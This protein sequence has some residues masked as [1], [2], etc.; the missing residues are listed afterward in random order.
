MSNAPFTID[1]LRTGI[2]LAYKNMEYI[3]DQALPRLPTTMRNYKYTLYNK[4]DR[5]T[6]PDTTIGRKGKVNEVEFG[7]TELTSMVIDRGLSDPIPQADIDAAANTDVD[8]LSDAAESVTDLIMLDREVRVA[9]I[10]MSASNYAT[11][12]A[13]SGT[14]QWDDPASD[15]IVQL[16]DAINTPFM[17]C[18]TLVLGRN[19]ANALRKNPAV[20]KAFNGTLGDSGL[21]PLSFLEQLLDIRILVGRA[22]KNT[23]NP[24]QTLTLADVWGTNAALYYLSP[25][26]KVNKGVTWGWTAEFKTREASTRQ[27]AKGEFGLDGG[28]SVLVGERLDEKVVCTD[29]G[30]IL[31]T[32]I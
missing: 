11:S 12:T 6:I 22:R 25:T 23:A 18:N 28:I 26:A 2:V 21:V 7:A 10:V 20:I 30:H 14:D 17:V 15:P 9:G 4:A 32:V 3:A 27:L 8:P 19:A 29:C 1:P 5:F 24:G 16:F 13:I 31:T